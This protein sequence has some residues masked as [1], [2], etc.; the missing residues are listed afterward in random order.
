M[1]TIQFMKVGSWG[2]IGTSCIIYKI[3][4]DTLIEYNN[5]GIQLTKIS[6]AR[7]DPCVKIL[8]NVTLTISQQTPTT[9]KVM[10]F[11]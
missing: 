10:D 8:D 1:T 4:N 3:N 11:K 9:L 7:E 5:F 2:K 6:S